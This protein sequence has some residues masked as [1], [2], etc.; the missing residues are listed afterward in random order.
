MNK[1]KYFITAATTK[2]A[3]IHTPKPKVLAGPRGECWF[4]HSES[5]LGLRTWGARDGAHLRTA[6]TVKGNGCVE[7]EF[8]SCKGRT[9][10]IRILMLR[11]V[12]Q[13]IDGSL[14]SLRGRN[15]LCLQPSGQQGLV[16]AVC[17]CVAIN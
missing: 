11:R 12:A 9:N 4:S 2:A 7:A 5:H 13:G 6:H 10:C 8:A 14:S 17:I 1:Q 16:E 3:K 15:S